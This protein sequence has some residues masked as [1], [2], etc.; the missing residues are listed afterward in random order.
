MLERENWRRLRE[1]TQ[2]ARGSVYL[3]LLLCVLQV[4]F[5]IGMPVSVF[6]VL[7]WM[8]DDDPARS[9]TAGYAGAVGL[10][11][12]ALLGYTLRDL[13]Q[14]TAGKAGIVARR[15]AVEEAYKHL[16]GTRLD[17]HGFTLGSV[18]V[19]VAE[20]DAI[21][22]LWPA[23]LGLVVQPVEAVLLIGVLFYFV[24]WGAIGGIATLFLAMVVSR[25]ASRVLDER[26]A[27]QASIAQQRNSLLAEVV[28]G[29]RVVKANGW[30]GKFFDKA[31]KLIDQEDDVI[32]RSG[33]INGC[34]VASGNNSVDII[35]L[36]V[37]S[38][39]VFA[40][41]NVLDAS[42]T[43]TY[44]IILA[45][46][47]GKLFAFPFHVRAVV[48]GN[49]ALTR[50]RNFLALAQ[51]SPPPPPSDSKQ[52]L[53]NTIAFQARDATFGRHSDPNESG[54]DLRTHGVSRVTCSVQ[55]GR[56]TAIVGPTGS[57]KSTLCAAMMGELGLTDGTSDSALYVADGC[58]DPEAR[59]VAYCPQQGF[60]FK[61]TVKQNIVFFSAFDAE[62]YQKVLQSCSLLAD[63]EGFADGDDTIVTASLL[64][65]GQKQRINL[66]RAAYCQTA[67]AWVLDDPLSAL[68]SVVAA[69]VLHE[70]IET[71]LGGTTRILVSNK[72]MAL[73]QCDA[74]I[75]LAAEGHMLAFVD[76]DVVNTA[77]VLLATVGSG[78]DDGASQEHGVAV[79]NGFGNGLSDN[80]G[81]ALSKADSDSGAVDPVADL[82]DDDEF[83]DKLEEQAR[84][85]VPPKGLAWMI[86]STLFATWHAWPTL[87]CLVGEV[88]AIEASVVVLKLWADEADDITRSREVEFLLWYM[89]C[90]VVLE[91]V[92]AVGAHVFLARAVVASHRRLHDQ[93]LAKVLAAP[94][95]YFSQTTSG[96]L[97]HLFASDL[98]LLGTQAAMAVDLFLLAQ[99]Y[100][101]VTVIVSL[102]FSVWLLIANGF[103]IIA[104]IMAMYCLQDSVGESTSQMTHA[105]VELLHWFSE[106]VA[107]LEV[108]RSF[109]KQ[110]PFAQ[111]LHEL[112]ESFAVVSVKAD[113]SKRSVGLLSSVIGATYIGI[114]VFTIVATDNTTP[115]EA[116]FVFVNAAFT[117]AM[118]QLVIE[119]RLDLQRLGF[120]RNFVQWHADTIPE[121]EGAWQLSSGT[122]SIPK[123]KL[124]FCGVT[125]VYPG[126]AKAALDNVS[127]VAEPNNSVGIVGRTG[128]GK[129]TLL[130]C[131]SRLVELTKGCIV[132]DGQDIAT[133]P[134]ND[135]RQAVAVISQDPLFFS[136]TV[137]HNLDPFDEFEDDALQARLADV[138][139]ASRMHL[140]SLVREQGKNF[141]LGQRQLLSLAR[142]LLQSPKVLLLDEATS[143]L[144][145]ETSRL[146]H[147]TIRRKFSNTTIIQIA[148]HIET[149]A[150]CDRILVMG[151]GKVQE[152]G[153]AQELLAA[154]GLFYTM[155]QA[156]GREDL[157]R[158]RELA[159]T[160]TPST[161]PSAIS[162]V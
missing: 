46:L 79:V 141:S 68:D 63:I 21:A 156:L 109:R 122:F 112:A 131:L 134:L 118:V 90:V 71:L 115:S 87:V 59:Q 69:H 125:V 84:S 58:S 97:V 146:I 85:S 138:G 86:T 2:H 22:A 23:L 103:L 162:S 111:R 91:L 128:A 74:A 104:I 145:P 1:L 108:V 40:L 30:T 24:S 82:V 140:D 25:L 65:G 66:A 159:A 12:S 149:V 148:H 114:S 135:L 73:R 113:R 43:F 36:A 6:V 143:S 151:D 150:D 161:D 99:L 89:L 61:G 142:A 154:G 20:T 47:H 158:V 81:T 3:A 9:D 67:E 19:L 60:I 49:L 155:A 10:T 137:R 37:I 157:D 52:E 160:V 35:S 55:K 75:T 32:A 38:I 119:Q 18:N 44:W 120:K 8:E 106:T 153:T 13:S 121:E 83:D 7:D 33:F 56:L 72:L 57:G 41:N 76:H 15:C 5:T 80:D 14:L 100:L 107:G 26:K 31:S 42:T 147:D 152:A 48:E 105:R 116:G 133:V 136:G 27:Q 96:T 124:E 28:W 17:N 77:G 4:V 130:A 51:V 126:Q 93:L 117:A 88:A 78:A 39:Y 102:V 98:K 123:G 101:L 62:R 127:F 139:L 50:L 95:S 11:L 132:I 92:F 110:G 129:S 144:D 34:I 70:C 45:I 64:S 53:D 94:L 29:I 54:K 16:L